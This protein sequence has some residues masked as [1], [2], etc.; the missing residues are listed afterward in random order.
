MPVGGRAATDHTEPL[1]KIDKGGD[2]GTET[3][4]SAK[5]TPTIEI[6]R[7][8]AEILREDSCISLTTVDR[9]ALDDV[10]GDRAAPPV[11]EVRHA[12]LRKACPFANLPHSRGTK[13]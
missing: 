7:G 8:V 2:P 4:A 13:T 3:D 11:R 1:S 9:E 12:E 10:S 6:E 5:P